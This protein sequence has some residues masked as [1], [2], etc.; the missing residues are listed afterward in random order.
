[1]TRPL[2]ARERAMVLEHEPLTR[3]VVN[4]YI[5]KCPSQAR[6]EDLEAL[7]RVRLVEL[8]QV[9]RP[10]EGVPFEG[11]AW[12]RLCGTVVDAL[13]A[14]SQDQARMR[15]AVSETEQEGEVGAEITLDLRD[16]PERLQ[17]TL[18]NAA[19]AAALGLISQGS[20]DAAKPPDHNDRHTL[21]D[22]VAKLPRRT[23]RV[24]ELR[25]LEDLAPSEVAARLGLGTATVF[26][27]QASG[28]AALHRM[29]SEG[30]GR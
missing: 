10:Q 23:R 9:Y 13:R 5:H 15:Q 18:D 6:R 8:F 26:R 29:M 19:V 20:A 17:Q 16:T 27:E 3:R 21:L 2:N 28:L 7:L 22:I 25:F 14:E 4:R 24:I 11:F 30:S 1:M 12:K